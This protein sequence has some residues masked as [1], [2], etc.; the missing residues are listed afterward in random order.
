MWRRASV[1]A[2]ALLVSSCATTPLETY[3][4]SH[5]G[6]K[7]D[8]PRAGIDA[9]ETLA[10]IYVPHQIEK[11]S[12]TEVREVRAF[13]LDASEVRDL[14]LDAFTSGAPGI[15]LIAAHVTCAAPKPIGWFYN[16]AVSWFVLRDGRL[17]AWR[18]FAFREYCHAVEA[19]RAIDADL[20]RAIANAEVASL[21][22]AASKPEQAA[23]SPEDAAAEAA[24][25][26]TTAFTEALA[27]ALKREPTIHTAFVSHDLVLTI[28]IEPDGSFEL[29]KI[30]PTDWFARQMVQQVRKV[31]GSPDRPQPPSCLRGKTVD[32]AFPR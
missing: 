11:G 25:P 29:E 31:S 13:S 8:F 7:P 14:A 24:C 23:P 19:T 10:S 16:D 3:E 15:S 12:I 2:L 27:E 9:Q 26:G 22:V 5:P 6:W 4:K 21:L 20:E 1:A 17:E 28:A 32:V 30:R 18:Y